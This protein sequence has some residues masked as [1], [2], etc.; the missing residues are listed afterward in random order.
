[1]EPSSVR[2]MA[3]HLLLI[4][5]KAGPPSPLSAPETPVET[6]RNT[7]S[8]LQVG[9]SVLILAVCQASCWSLLCP[10]LCVFLRLSYE[11]PLQSLKLVLLLEKC[12]MGWSARGDTQRQKARARVCRAQLVSGPPLDLLFHKYLLKMSVTGNLY[13]GGEL[14]NEIISQLPVCKM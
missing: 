14:P 9:N 4:G 11:F 1:M 10:A 6:Q 8:P 3:T 12:V 13:S 2:L 7:S 5:D